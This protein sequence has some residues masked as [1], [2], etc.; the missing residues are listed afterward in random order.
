MPSIVW[1]EIS[2]SFPDFNGPVVVW[3]WISNSIIPPHDL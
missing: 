3:E 1:Q 2:Y